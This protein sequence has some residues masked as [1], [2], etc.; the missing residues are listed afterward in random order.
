[1]N[2]LTD[3]I[4]VPTLVTGLLLMAIGSSVVTYRQMGEVQTELRLLA[5]EVRKGT[6]D[7]YTKAEALKDA[8]ASI[9]ERAYINNQVIVA[10]RDIDR[11]EGVV[12]D[13]VTWREVQKMK[14][15][16]Q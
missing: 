2:K 15:K 10:R 5:E 14:D 3:L 6:T 11:L 16:P 13:L 8:E 7:R 9:K 1:M 12:Q 4:N